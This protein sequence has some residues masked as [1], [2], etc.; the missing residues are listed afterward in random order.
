M[1]VRKLQRDVR[2]PGLKAAEE[3]HAAARLLVDAGWLVSP[4]GSGGA[5]RRRQAYSV[6]PHIL[7]MA[8]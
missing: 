4:K 2:L 8:P 7:E 3:I 6:N 1:H 5:G